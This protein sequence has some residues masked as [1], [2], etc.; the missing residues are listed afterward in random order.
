MTKSDDCIDRRTFLGSLGGAATAILSGCGGSSRNDDPESTATTVTK[1]TQ[2]EASISETRSEW[3]RARELLD[4]GGELRD[5]LFDRGVYVGNPAQ[6]SLGLSGVRGELQ[7]AE[8]AKRIRSG[9][10]TPEEAWNE[11]ADRTRYENGQ[12][13]IQ[14][15]IGDPL[16]YAIGT[17]D[18][19]GVAVYS[20]S[21]YGPL[22]D[23]TN[24]ATDALK[25]GRMDVETYFLDE[26]PEIE[27]D[28]EN[29]PYAPKK[30]GEL[31]VVVGEMDDGTLG[32]SWPSSNLVKINPES[33]AVAGMNEADRAGA[34][35]NTMRHEW[36][37]TLYS[38]PHVLRGHLPGG[39][40]LMSVSPD[41]PQSVQKTQQT[42]I[43]EER[44][45]S[46]ALTL[47]AEA[48][49]DTTRLIAELEP[50]DSGE[51]RQQGRKVHMQNAQL[52]YSAAGLS[53]NWNI[54][55]ANGN[56][57]ARNGP[58]VLEAQPNDPYG[59]ESFE[60]KRVT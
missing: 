14:N 26:A 55:I 35:A 1:E 40:P 60:A 29:I 53:D 25:G 41:S 59:V 27:E 43:I 13:L 5:R 15:E 52:L 39:E 47:D 11:V 36:E 20:D 34:I 19:L 3:E 2:E 17:G 54:D 6:K 9:E 56:S 32:R 22:E 37:H 24:Q 49:A 44:Y 10:A 31:V 28:G 51:F 38:T 7:N 50:Q 4:D 58:Y 33:D 8:L 30:A 42:R 45:K 57:I 23:V 16:D 46:S 18:A 48:E 12:A 21:E